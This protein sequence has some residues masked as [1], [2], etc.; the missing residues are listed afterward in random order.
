MRY[1][2]GYCKNTVHVH[3]Q[4]LFVVQMDGRLHSWKADSHISAESR[5]APIEGK[6]LAVADALEKPRYFVLGYND[7][8]IAVDHIPLL[9]VFS[10]HGKDVT[11]QVQNDICT[12]SQTPG[13]RL[14]IPPSNQ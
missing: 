13:D 9:R 11:L 2:S 14:P 6:A 4:S 10:D 5:Y 3:Q 7:L 8:T 12:W 1:E